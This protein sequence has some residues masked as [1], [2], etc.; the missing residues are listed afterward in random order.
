MLAGVRR[1]RKPRFVTA[2]AFG[3]DFFPLFPVCVAGESKGGLAELCGVEEKDL[4][5]EELYL[6][7]HG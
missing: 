7:K 3:A 1:E 4:E 5:E 2:V 6:E